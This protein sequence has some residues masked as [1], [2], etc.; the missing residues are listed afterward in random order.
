MKRLIFLLAMVIPVV[1]FAGTTGKIAGKITDR[2]TNDPLVGA[3]VILVGTS[4]GASV[5]VDGSYV[6][7]N[8]PP[9]TYSVR[10]TMIGYTPKVINGARVIVDQTTTL[11]AT[12]D[13][14]SVL[15]GEVVI[16]ADRPMIQKD[17]TSTSYIVTS[18]QMQ[19]LPVRNFIE[20]LNMQAGVVSEGNT[21]Y[22][23]GG[24]GNEVAFLIDGMYVN[25]PVMGGLAT[26]ISN[27]AISELNFLSGTFNAEYGN[28]LS[29]VVNI[30]TR[31]GGKT[32]AGNFEAR[33]SEF[34]VAP[35]NNYRENRV[36]VT[37]SGPVLGDYTSFFVTGER[38]ARSSWLPFGSDQ[39]RSIMAK[40]TAKFAP[41]L[42]GVLTWR[43]G[44]DDRRPYNHSWKYIP[45][46]YL[47]VREKSRQIIA[48]ITHTVAPNFFYDLH[49]SYFNQSYYSGVDKD[50]SQYLGLDAW[51]YLAT[52][53]TGFEF[54]AK[55][56]PIELTDNR[57]QTLNAKGDLVWQI[58]KNN[59]IKSGFELKKH[60]LK[61]FDD[62]DPKRNFPYITDF[63]KEPF[64][65]S[66]YAQD[67]IEMNAFVMNLGMRFDYADQLSPFR[68]NPLVPT[69]IVASKP[70][71]QWSPRLG[72][73]HPISDRTS[74]HFSYGHFFQNPD[75]TRLYENSQYDVNVREPIFG[76]PNL[77]A[78]RTTAYEVGV[79]H[80]F[81]EA[82]VGSFTAYYK[83]VI[84]LV[85]TQYFFPY[86][87][88]RYVGY[89]LYV[90]EAYANIKGFEVRVD[91][92]RTKYLSGSMTYT[93]SVAKGSASSETED[94]PGTTTSTL[95]YPLGF[96]KPHMFNLN[97]NLY[98]PPQT[99]LSVFGVY[100]LE[101]TIWNFVVRA[102]SGY[103]YTPTPNGRSISY[104]EKNSARMP[105]TYSVDAQISKEWKF[106][107][108]K[109]TIFAEILNLTDHK[110][111]LYVYT[112]TGEP[113][114]TYSG[115]YSQDYMHDPSNF[116]PPRRIR[117]G[118]R[119]GF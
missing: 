14:A 7:L 101:N 57:T 40:A 37:L 3:N 97:A 84:G 43:Y 109:V 98:L 53:G 30:I 46:Q 23:R 115:G 28:A 56:D 68:S 105:M 50:T 74:L 29:G 94:Y 55:R 111:V 71:L 51:S 60:K 80:Q 103:P 75:Y 12:L 116:G 25:D 88:G 113:D 2:T 79:S 13:V 21:L 39:T 86:V 9:G 83:D 18:E 42:K 81:G 24:R 106:S 91:L 38:D 26:Q 114:V 110:N 66:V 100:P 44:D 41:E 5:G 27:E 117:L 45:D 49:F 4:L 70:K 93:Y 102:S 89:T 62:Y 95:L 20:V 17:M 10:V 6:I 112:D 35:Y 11:N 58:N 108:T 34:G 87:E 76:Q 32:F 104:I 69:S 61:Y 96:D 72:V 63:T 22:V 85:G 54:Y 118:A 33:T 47:K 64:E 31:E 1:A 19:V 99:G 67:K 119:F 107:S 48:S 59:E 82:L 52:A 78:E 15:M 8:I 36:D 92:R 16:Q 77:D 73:A 90:N 65:G